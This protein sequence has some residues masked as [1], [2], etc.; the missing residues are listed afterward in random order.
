[1]TALRRT[2]LVAAQFDI[3]LMIK[4]IPSEENVLA[5]TLS[6]FD[7]V[8]IAKLAPQLGLHRRSFIKG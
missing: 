8:R 4:W 5:D 7:M 6:H 2:L 3:E 1:M